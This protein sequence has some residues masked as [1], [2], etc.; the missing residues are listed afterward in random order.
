VTARSPWL[1][2][3]SEQDLNINLDGEPIVVKKL[4]AEVDRR[5]LPVPLGDSALLSGA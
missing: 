1:E 3:E 2:Y 5:A 4:R